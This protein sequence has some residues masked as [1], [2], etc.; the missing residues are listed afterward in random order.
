VKNIYFLT[1]RPG[2]GKT[3]AILEVIKILKEEGYQVGGMISKDKREK[4]SRVGFEVRNIETGETGRLAHFNQPE[5]PRVGRYRVDLM[6]LN[7]VGVKAIIGAIDVS[8]IIVIDEIG[9]MELY[10]ISFKDAVLK[11]ID[12]GK[13]V[14]GTIHYRSKD[15]FIHRIRDLKDSEIIEV[16]EENRDRIPKDVSQRILRLLELN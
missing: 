12:S 1:G 11:S 4:G 8:D 5:G 15:P 14:L 9:P 3:S 13:P 2:V 16:T 7:S 6:S 10:S